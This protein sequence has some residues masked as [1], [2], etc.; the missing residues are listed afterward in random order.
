M[1]FDDFECI[2]FQKWD[3]NGSQ[4]SIK[5]C[6]KIGPIFDT[7]WKGYILRSWWI[8]DTKMGTN[9]LP[10]FV[11]FRYQLPKGHFLFGGIIPDGF[12]WFWMYIVSKMGH[13]RKPTS[14]P[15]LDPKGN[16]SGKRFLWYYGGFWSP[17]WDPKS[18]KKLSKNGSK[19]GAPK[20]RLVEASGGVLGASWASKIHQPRWLRLQWRGRRAPSLGFL[21][22]ILYVYP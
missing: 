19:K 13:Q 10:T 17:E 9:G 16:A 20:K 4:H 5:I 22:I 14:V 8:W 21:R 6:I 15:K 2:L 12:W 1:D 7:P 3:T 11:K 18:L